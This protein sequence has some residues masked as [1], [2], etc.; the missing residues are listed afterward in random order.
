MFFDRDVEPTTARSEHDLQ[1]TAIHRKVIGAHRST[2]S[3]DA[4]A[5]FR[6]LLTNDRKRGEVIAR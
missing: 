6:T 4:S 2:S 5:T 3:A 1:P